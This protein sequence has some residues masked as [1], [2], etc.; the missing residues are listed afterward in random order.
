MLRQDSGRASKAATVTAS[1]GGSSSN[2]NTY[3]PED[4]D[5][6]SGGTH[7]ITM[8]EVQRISGLEDQHVE[9]VFELF[10]AE[11]TDQGY[12]T[13]DGFY[14]AFAT[15]V[16]GRIE[17]LGEQDRR[18]V[19]FVVECLFRSLDFNGDGLLDF[20][21]LA[22]GISVLCGGS[23]DDKVQAAFSLFDLNNDGFISL[24]EM[25]TYLTS[26]FCTLYQVDPSLATQTNC[27]PEELA[28]QT[29]M[30]A[31]ADADLNHDGKLSFE[32]FTRW[33]MM[34]GGG[35][36]EDEDEDDYDDYDEEDE[37]EED[38]E[39]EDE[40]EDEDEDEEDEEEEEEEVRTHRAGVVASTATNEVNVRHSRPPI[41]LPWPSPTSASLL[42]SRHTAQRTSL[43]SSHNRQITAA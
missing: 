26:M 29:A 9:D 12:I 31:F 2:T 30:Q 36:D 15:L 38:E 8:A 18:R 4:Y 5:L 35:D 41:P 28:Q 22:S 1:P 7:P 24:E 20:A 19:L 32:E 40:D 33:Y 13:K 3:D 27:G 16:R 6:D 42:P 11:A 37:D 25:I 34:E 21:E 43:T 17:G 10:A 39:E 23:R 14:G